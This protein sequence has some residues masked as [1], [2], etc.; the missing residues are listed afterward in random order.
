ME[1]I[2]TDSRVQFF[3][4]RKHNEKT[5]Q[6]HIIKLFKTSDKEKNFKNFPTFGSIFCKPETT[7]KNQVYLK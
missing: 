2:K 6:R 4:H 7:I 3:K 1:T 5:T